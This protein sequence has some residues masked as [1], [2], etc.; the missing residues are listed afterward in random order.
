MFEYIESLKLKPGHIRERI[1]LGTAAGV[2]AIVAVGWVTVVAS[3]GSFALA[4]SDN[5][6]DAAS[7]IGA[8]FTNTQSGFNSLL[9]AVG[10]MGGNEQSGIMV[11]TESSTTLDKGNPTVIPF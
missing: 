3:S 10:A 5:T 1:A 4:P 11:E 8:A 2:T 6:N 9:G 7:D